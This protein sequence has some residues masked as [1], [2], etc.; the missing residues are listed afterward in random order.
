MKQVKN[1]ESIGNQSSPTIKIFIFLFIL[2]GAIG[3]FFYFNYA[4]KKSITP[5]VKVEKIVEEAKPEYKDEICNN[6][7]GKQRIIYF[8]KNKQLT[9]N[10]FMACSDADKILG[11]TEFMSLGENDGMLFVFENP[12]FYK[13]WMQ[14]TSIYISAAFLNEHFEI[15]EIHDLEPLSETKV[16][17]EG[18]KTK[19][20][21]EMNKGWFEKNNIQVG[22][23]LGYSKL[24]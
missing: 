12:D 18:Q 14:D 20:V 2:F 16:G 3:A 8:E 23:K 5:S 19:Y 17:P 24:K 6:F 4:E 7:T 15:I 22:D 10:S 9:I 13:F 1:P 21:L 11:L